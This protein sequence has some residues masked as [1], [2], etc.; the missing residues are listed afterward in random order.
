MTIVLIKH[1]EVK[2]RKATGTAK[3]A[4]GPQS[5][6]VIYQY[7]YMLLIHSIQYGWTPH[8]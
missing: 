2:T 8:T 7:P 6:Y 4:G 1:E 3:N 5:P